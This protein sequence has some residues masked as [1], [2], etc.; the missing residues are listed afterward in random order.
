MKI[1][2]C[3][4][5]AL[6]HVCTAVFASQG[7]EVSVLTNHPVEWEK[8]IE[9]TDPFGRTIIGKVYR[10]SDNPLVVSQGVDLFL[11]CV[12]GGLLEGELKKIKPFVKRETAVGAIV[13]STGF[14][15]FAHEIL[16]NDVCLFG[17]Q[18][19]PFIARVVEYGSK[20]N[21][22]GY[23]KQ[24]AI[25]VENI[26]DCEGFRKQIERLFITPVV[27]LDT[28]YEASLTNSNPILHTGR[29]YSLWKDWNGMSYEHCILF[30]REWTEE[31]A[32]VIIDMDREFQSLLEILPMNARAVPSLLDYYESEDARSLADK[33]RT[34][35]AFQTIQAPMVK[36]DKG[37][38]PDFRSHYFT[39]DFPYGLRFIID[40]AHQYGLATPLMDEVYNWGISH[41]CS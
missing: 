38:L 33:L 14:F 27:L 30:Y 18:R 3:G 35:E 36:T 32:Q 23:K 9:T 22:L 16:G 8:H 2:I 1:C 17:F 15:F 20:A 37:W 26:P 7:H 13:S 39:E 24:V 31:A 41:V 5:G 28:F 6:G 25:A 19:T 10:V 34:I 21:L 29:L 40:L 12:P 11:L 4:G